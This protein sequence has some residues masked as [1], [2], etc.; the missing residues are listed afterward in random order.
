MMKCQH[1]TFL[2]DFQ[3]M[4]KDL[5][6]LLMN[7]QCQKTVPCTH[8]GYHFHSEAVLHL[9]W[10]G[11]FHLRGIFLLFAASCVF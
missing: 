10:E 8:A 6:C 9:T 3:R 1:C 11:E 7:P 2:K 4:A 5:L